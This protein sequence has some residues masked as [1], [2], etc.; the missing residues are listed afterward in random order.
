MKELTIEEKALRY[1]GS[2]ERAKEIN[3]EHSKKGFKP[4]DDILYIFPELKESEDENIRKDIIWCL[5]HSG[6]KESSPIN[7]HVTTIK[8]DAIAWLEKQGKK[9]QG[10]SALEAINEEKADNANKIE[11]KFHKGDWVVNTITNVVEQIIDITSNE[12]ICSVGLIVSFD[13]QHLLKKWTIED[14]KDGDILVS[15]SN[16]PFI[17]NGKMDAQTIGSHGGVL[18]DGT[19]FAC[20]FDDCNWTDIRFIHPATKE[21]R[22][23]L[24]SKMKEAGYKLD[25]NFNAIKI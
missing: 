16:Q 14:T 24:F 21:Q 20:G 2:I 8:R 5:K 1:D 13:N 22:D 7:P 10:K 18:S 12:Y 4:S 11:P 23:L 19:A 17:Y 25:L 3:R 6:I 15:R 9:P